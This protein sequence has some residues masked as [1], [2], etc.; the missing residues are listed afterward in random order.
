MLTTTSI[1]AYFLPEVA[2]ADIENMS[3]LKFGT[4]EESVILHSPVLSSSLLSVI[5]TQLK[6]AREV[7]L[8][9]LS[10]CDIIDCIDSI[11][12][13]WQNPIYPLRQQ[14]E[15]LLP[16]ITGYSKPMIVQGIDKLVSMF[17]REN[18]EI[19]LQEEL[20]DPLFLDQF[21]PRRK[22]GGLSRAY[23]PLLTTHIFA[24]NVPGL[25]AINLIN[26]LLVKSASL[27]KAASEEP[28][29]PVL[30]TRS[31]SEVNPGLAKCIAILHWKGGDEKIEQLAFTQSDAVIVYGSELAVSS[32]HA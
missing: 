7:Y 22:T 5:I 9:R 32:V 13:L 10:V 20:G 31:L 12:T 21:R 14:A 8:A 30:F 1:P 23:G 3:T 19:L 11:T 15:A 29:F 26:A 27:G 28:L 4:G 24:G 18:L 16:V 25:P 2:D 6:K 17:K